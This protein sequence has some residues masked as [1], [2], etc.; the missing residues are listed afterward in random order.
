MPMIAGQAYEKNCW[1]RYKKLYYD[2]WWSPIRYEDGKNMDWDTAGKQGADDAIYD[3]TQLNNGNLVFVGHKL[4]N[5]GLATPIWI[6]VTDSIGKKF[7]WEKLA[8]T[9]ISSEASMLPMS[10]AASP[11]GGF[12]VVGFESQGAT[13]FDG[14]VMHFIP[15]PASAATSNGKEIPIVSE[16]RV[17]S[18]S[19]QKIVF[20]LQNPG[21]FPA[22]LSVFSA[23][24]KLVARKAFKGTGSGRNALV[25]NCGTFGKGVYLYR[26]QSN[27][28]TDRGALVVGG[29]NW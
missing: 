17:I 12:S 13:G 16:I 7:L 15:K 1:K 18:T 2:A 19:P 24:G 11:D 4:E 29:A 23:S 22:N 14:F 6:F 26:L 3:F 5:I 20:S 27:G 8:Y 28:K 10:V 25:W 9:G 21:A